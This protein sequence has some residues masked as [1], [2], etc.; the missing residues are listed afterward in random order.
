VLDRLDRL[1]RGLDEREMATVAYIVLDPSDGTLEM[2]LAGHLSPLIVSPDGGARYL[3]G[4]RSRP[5]GVAAARRYEASSGRL[6]R[7]E[8][9]VLFTDG[10]VE[11]RGIPIDDGLAALREAAASAASLDP[12]ALCDRLIATVEAASVPDDVAVLVIALPA[13]RDE[14]LALTLAAEPGSLVVMRRSLQS[15]LAGAGVGEGLGYDILVAVGEAAAN[16]IEHAYGPSEAEFRIEAHVADGELTV[17]VRDEGSWRPARGSHRGRG[18]TMM[19]KLMDD[20]QVD[21][22]EGGTVV[23]MRRKL[24][25]AP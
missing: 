20:V 25:V 13:E 17:S 2:A 14:R 3:D 15:W 1:V 12:D 18:L 8:T 23:T 24:E 6:E 7:G 10:L 22:D 21:S 19:R 9:I 11:R 5:I 4:V 16:A